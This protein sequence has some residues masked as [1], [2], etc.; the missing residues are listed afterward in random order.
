[1]PM[2]T[3][4]IEK[5]RCLTRNDSIFVNQQSIK[6]VYFVKKNSECIVIL[7]IMKIIK[8]TFNAMRDMR[9]GKVHS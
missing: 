3:E 2:Y 5:S 7:K 6:N 9:E 1:M 4:N 8:M